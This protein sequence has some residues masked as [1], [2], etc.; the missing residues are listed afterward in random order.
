L[1]LDAPDDATDTPLDP[2]TDVPMPVPLDATLLALLVPALV[3]P[4]DAATE[5]LVCTAEDDWGPE[6]PPCEVLD[7]GRLEDLPLL[8]LTPEEAAR[9]L[10]TT[11]L[12]ELLEV[13]APVPA[14]GSSV[15]ATKALHPAPNANVTSVKPSTLRM[16]TSRPVVQ[17]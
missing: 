11:T 17:P 4:P 7:A 6:D 15:P 13:P 8:L 10:L 1:V 2:S 14:S 3:L 5:L 12:P 9:E 16:C